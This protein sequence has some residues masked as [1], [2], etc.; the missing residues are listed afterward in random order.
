MENRNEVEMR[1]TME[2]RLG[3]LKERTEPFEFLAAGLRLM[4]N[5]QQDVSI[6]VPN[7]IP[8]K[9]EL[10]TKDAVR[11]YILAMINETCELLQELDW[12]PWKSKNTIDIPKVVDEFAD[13][14]A[15]QGIIIHYLNLLGITPN[16]L[17]EGYR[18]KSIKNI[19]RLFGMHESEYKQLGL[20]E[21]EGK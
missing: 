16:M 12:K 7:C 18:L 1:S 14:L 3:M 19:E 2:Y 17:A 11:T 13:I 5:V 8:P 10:P 6:S 21:S 4:A 9:N 20:F 15:F